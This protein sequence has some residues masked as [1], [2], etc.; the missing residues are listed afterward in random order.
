MRNF[1]ERLR[2]ER[3]VGPD[4]G[5]DMDV[6]MGRLNVP[7]TVDGERHAGLGDQAWG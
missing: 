7:G 1:L 6:G 4:S 5:S 3:R 2:Q